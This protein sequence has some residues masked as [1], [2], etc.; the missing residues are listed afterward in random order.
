M[1]SKMILQYW[2]EHPLS[3]FFL[4]MQLIAILILTAAASSATATAMQY[5]R[6]FSDYFRSQGM[7]LEV[8]HISLDHKNV[9]EDSKELKKQL[10]Q[11]EVL[12]CYTLQAKLAGKL[13]VTFRAYDPDI[14]RRYQPHLA[15]GSWLSPEVDKDGMLHAVVWGISAK[16]GDVIEAVANDEHVPVKVIGILDE[17]ATIVGHTSGSREEQSDYM[18][19]Y[20]RFPNETLVGSVVLLNQA[21]IL[22]AKDSYPGI[23][24]PMSDMVL[25]KYDKHIKERDA[26]RNDVLIDRYADTLNGYYM[27]DLNDQSLRNIRPM[28]YFFIP[29]LIAAFSLM[30]VSAICSNAVVMEEQLYPFAVF[31]LCGMTRNQCVWLNFCHIVLDVIVA[32]GI[33]VWIVRNFVAGRSIMKITLHYGWAELVC[34]LCVGAFYLLLALIQ[35]YLSLNK[36]TVHAILVQHSGK[37]R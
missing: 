24:S 21:E 8:N 28:L 9:C 37:A 33:S 35:P 34:C 1:R 17:D 5:Y 10:Q 12:S 22:A 29:L 4:I 7:F 11:A 16:V 20:T 13:N 32:E 36:Q 15:Q 14:I 31:R 23:S 19:M 26:K 6:P 27:K 3:S 30:C 25:I 2:K 18:Q